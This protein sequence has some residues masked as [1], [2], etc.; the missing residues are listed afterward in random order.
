MRVTGLNGTTSGI[1]A[2]PDWQ[3]K[4]FASERRVSRLEDAIY[5]YLTAPTKKTL[6]ALWSELHID[7]TECG[8]PRPQ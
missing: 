3:A 4:Y 8:R 5:S 7:G 2:T 6:K 1:D